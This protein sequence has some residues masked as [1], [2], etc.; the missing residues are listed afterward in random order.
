MKRIVA[1]AATLAATTVAAAAVLAP[2]QAATT[3][4]TVTTVTVKQDGRSFSARLVQPSGSAPHAY[5]VIAFGHGFLQSTSQYDSTLK[6]LAARGYVV[7]APNS[8]GGLFPSHS[9]F[10]A[11]LSAAAAWAGRT[12]P[13][14]DAATEIVGGHSMGGGAAVLAASQDTSIDGL[15]TLAAAETNPSAKAAAAKVTVPALFVTGTKDTVIPASQSLGIAAA[16]AGP[17]DTYS[18]EGG[19]HCGYIDTVAFFGIGCD[20]GT[21]SRANQLAVTQTVVGLWLDA[22][23]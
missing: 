14:A 9:A 21:I 11:D 15:F 20:K 17:R 5:P 18:I 13:N 22:R 6:S 2:A 8:Q 12:Q 10:A 3:T 16:L 19:F 23:F 7:I 4:T 1:L